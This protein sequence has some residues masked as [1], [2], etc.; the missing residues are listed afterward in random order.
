ML[1]KLL[2]YGNCQVGSLNEIFKKSFFDYEIDIVLCWLDDINKDKFLNKIKEADIIITQPIHKGYKNLDYLHTEYILEN[3]KET[4]KIYIFP[5][6]YFNFY[7]FDLSYK[8]L[9]NGELLREPSDYHYTSLIKCFQENKSINYYLEEIVNNNNYKNNIELENM[10]IDSINELSKRENEI[11]DY[12]KIKKCKIIK[13]SNFIENNYKDKLLFY[14]M[15]HPAKYIFHYIAEFILQDLNINNNINYDIDPLYNHERCILY[16]TI[17]KVVHFNINENLP[18]L[19]N[20]NLVD[21]EEIT[22]KY[23]EIYKIKLS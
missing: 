23:Y 22:N 3:S 16:K 10:A 6:L 9:Q 19:H 1:K 18:R 12:N 4:A 5:S 7:Y 20:C 21:L 8:T 17:Q 2:L 14:S 13:C 15:N 11:E